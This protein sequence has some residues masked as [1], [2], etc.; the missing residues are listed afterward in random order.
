[1]P[2][3]SNKVWLATLLWDYIVHYVL[4]NSCV[5]VFVAFA[6]ATLGVRGECEGLEGECGA[7]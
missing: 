1:M 2:G 4:G 3:P 5:N 6:N 7:V